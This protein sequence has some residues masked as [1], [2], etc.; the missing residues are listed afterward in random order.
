ME[1]KL[2]VVN[3]RMQQGYSY[4]LSEAIGGIFIP[5]SNPI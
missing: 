3:D 1:R 5:T 4:F 2:V